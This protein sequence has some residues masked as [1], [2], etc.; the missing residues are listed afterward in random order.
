MKSDTSIENDYN[1]LEVVVTIDFFIPPQIKG[2]KLDCVCCLM[3]QYFLCHK[4]HFARKAILSLTFV[5]SVMYM[6]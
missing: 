2:K 4:C 5:V 3:S 1:T 6:Y